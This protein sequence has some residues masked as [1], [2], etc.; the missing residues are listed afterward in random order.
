MS[1]IGR[2]IEYKDDDF[3]SGLGLRHIRDGLFSI[4]WCIKEGPGAFESASIILSRP[5]DQETVMTY[6]GGD[7]LHLPAASVISAEDALA[8]MTSFCK[9]GRVPLSW[10]SVRLHELPPGVYYAGN[11][12]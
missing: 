7:S 2:S 12:P 6:V 10:N 9:E 3:L 8:I 5:A 4:V 1:L 11:E